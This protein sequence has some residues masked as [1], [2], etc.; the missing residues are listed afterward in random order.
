VADEHSA[1][2]TRAEFDKPFTDTRLFQYAT[3]CG[4]Y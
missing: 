1:D 3:G 4:R 2:F